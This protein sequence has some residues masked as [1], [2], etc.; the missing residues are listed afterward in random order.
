MFPA[1]ERPP[2]RP[3][4]VYEVEEGEIGDAERHGE[5]ARNAGGSS[6]RWILGE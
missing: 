5:L 6:G 4:A 2:V 3:G 1:G